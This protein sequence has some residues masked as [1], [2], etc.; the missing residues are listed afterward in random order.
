MA[1]EKRAYPLWTELPYAGKTHS[2][3]IAG[4]VE[5]DAGKW[6]TYFIQHSRRHGFKKLDGRPIRLAIKD[7]DSIDWYAQLK[8]VQHTLENLS[9]QEKRIAE[10]WSAG[11]PTKQW[12]PIVDRLID[13]YAIE[14]PRAAR[15]L[16][17]VFGGMNDAFVVC[18]ALKY[19][20][21]VPRPNQLDQHLATYICTPEHPSYPSGHATISGAAEV[22][23][24]YFFPAERQKLH[25][26]AEENAQ[27]RLYA[28]VHYP[29]DNTEGLRLG[30]QIG[31]IVIEEL[32]KD[33]V[34]GLPIE[35][36]SREFR[37]A[38]IITRTYEQAIPFDY[39]SKCDSLLIRD[40]ES[41]GNSSTKDWID[42]KLFI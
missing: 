17:A 7:P 14:A 8:V 2:P 31:R 39:K 35:R 28:G 30:R 20:W 13:T 27:S 36:S 3:T 29:V 16:S 23:L 9:D 38:D 11:P 33:T 26:L 42:P 24:S 19:K 41:T 37:N 25:R 32:K 18:W 15:I 5:P 34:N 40:D 1:H 10:Y 12:I 4:G 6:K 21:L 22:I